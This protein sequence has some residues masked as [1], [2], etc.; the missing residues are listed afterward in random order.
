M[1]D[2]G[3]EPLQDS[4]EERG[5]KGWQP[6][7]QDEFEVEVSDLALEDEGQVAPPM[8]TQRE[9]HR[10]RRARFWRVLLVV[11]VLLALLG[12]LA[13]NAALRD[14]AAVLLVGTPTPTALPAPTPTL[15]PPPTPGPEEWLALEE[16]SLFLPMLAPGSACPTSRG[17]IISRYIGPVV[18][19][20]PAYAAYGAGSAIDGVLEYSDARFLGSGGLSAWGF[21]EVVW[22]IRPAYNGPILVRG[23]QIDG[24]NLV[25]FNGGIDQNQFVGSWSNA[26]LL[27]ELRLVGNPDGLT[28]SYWGTYTRLLA[29]GCYAYQVDGLDFSYIII[30]RAVPAPGV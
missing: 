15:A 24:P 8:R 16:R 29:P 26:P 11:G 21:Q 6:S 22:A 12:M 27:T 17:R 2:L 1:S 25:L 7:S 30:F 20:G 14:Q 23:R 19:P 28:W 5:W 9:A 10:S 3:P 13:S 18:G 4:A